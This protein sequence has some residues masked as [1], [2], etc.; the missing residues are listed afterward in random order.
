MSEVFKEICIF[1]NK[2]F[3]FTNIKL[4]ELPMCE[5]CSEWFHKLDEQPND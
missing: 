2:E 5:D 1:C 4:K 3:I